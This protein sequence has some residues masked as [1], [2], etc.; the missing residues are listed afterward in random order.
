MAGV[1]PGS[2][3]PSSKKTIPKVR[4]PL[5]I[6]GYIIVSKFIAVCFLNILVFVFT[7]AFL[8]IAIPVSLLAKFVQKILVF[9]RIKCQNAKAEYGSGSENFWFLTN[10]EGQTPNVVLLMAVKGR[11]SCENVEYLLHNRL[12]YDNEGHFEERA[13]NFKR[14]NRT[15]KRVF[16]ELVWMENNVECRKPVIQADLESACLFTT[17]GNVVDLQRFS[18]CNEWQV[19]LY[20]SNGNVGDNTGSI[21]VLEFRHCIADLHSLVYAISKSFL[22]RQVFIFRDEITPAQ[23]FCLG[24]MALLAGPSIFM[25][26]LLKSKDSTFTEPPFG[27]RKRAIFYSQTISRSDVDIVT[28]ATG[29]SGKS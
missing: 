11:L 3:A 25:K 22:D 29:T 26:M 9:V 13:S 6:P 17:E 21:I 23:G 8:F 18:N 28:T 19:Y 2:S 24:F 4:H 7:Y 16:R 10:Y 15:P 14:L 1:K 27:C 12:N 20:S 5:A